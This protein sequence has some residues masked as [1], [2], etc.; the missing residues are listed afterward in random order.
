M[1]LNPDYAGFSILTI[2]LSRAE[3]DDPESEFK[4]QS[5]LCGILYSNEED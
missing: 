1:G 2:L 3:K 4:S 5:R